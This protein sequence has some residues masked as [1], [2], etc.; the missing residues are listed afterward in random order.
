[1]AN[2]LAVVEGTPVPDVDGRKADENHQLYVYL[3]FK[4]HKPYSASSNIKQEENK[5]DSKKAILDLP[6]LF[7]R[8]IHS[9]IAMFQAHPVLDHVEMFIPRKSFFAQKGYDT[10]QDQET[11]FAIY[12]NSDA[13]KFQD[14]YYRDRAND[15]GGPGLGN[16]IE[17]VATFRA[18]PV[19]VTD[20]Q[21]TGIY[22]ACKSASDA[23]ARAKSNSSN[24]NDHGQ[25]KY[26]SPT[27]FYYAFAAVPLRAFARLLPQ[28]GDSPA[29]CASLCARILKAANIHLKHSEH[30]YSPSTLYLETSS[31][32]I[33]QPTIE[34]IDSKYDEK[35]CNKD[36]FFPNSI[37]ALTQK[38]QY[39][40]VQGL[41]VR[42]EALYKQHHH[43]TYYHHQAHNYHN[44][45]DNHDSAGTNIQS[46]QP[47]C[48]F[49]DTYALE[50]Q[51][52]KVLFES[53]YPPK[54]DAIVKA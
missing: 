7:N 35:N 6:D 18:V 28:K 8:T 16:F 22:D 39:N 32:P 1:M 54:T 36:V 15:V 49:E 31:L 45:H 46:S 23:A 33:F 3:I 5:E 11:N 47:E 38:E 53:R 13:A 20:A 17:E 10:D 44:H 40:L 30:W 42:L 24:A 41:T 25:I 50:T 52:A 21:Y 34:A 9:L 26:G 37:T 2:Q 27:L 43:H 48:T 29:Q 4:D 51:L 19:R 14:S 12:I